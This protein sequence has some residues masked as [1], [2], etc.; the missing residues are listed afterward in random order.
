MLGCF[1]VIQNALGDN[2]AI[3]LLYDFF[4]VCVCLS[5]FSMARFVYQSS[6]E[7]EVKVVGL[8]FSAF[9]LSIALTCLGLR[10]SVGSH[11]IDMANALWQLSLAIY[12][13]SI[14]TLHHT[15]IYGE[16]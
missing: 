9:L 3:S 8:G 11:M 4:A 7:A 15:A 6:I 13:L 12:V 1:S 10:S 5:T 16:D 2:T 14:T